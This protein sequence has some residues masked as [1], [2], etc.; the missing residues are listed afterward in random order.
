MGA[1]T[2]INS[3]ISI[4]EDVNATKPQPQSLANVSQVCAVFRGVDN[5][6]VNLPTFPFTGMKVLLLDVGNG[7]GNACTINGNGHQIGKVGGAVAS[8]V[9]ST[10]YQAIELTYADG[11]A[12]WIVSSTT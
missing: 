6:A 11:A 7:A 12:S 3:S 10:D 8:I 5:C 2:Q 4:S 9:M 1:L